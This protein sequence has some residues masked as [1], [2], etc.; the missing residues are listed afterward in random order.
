MTFAIQGV[1]TAAHLNLISRLLKELDLPEHVDQRVP[2]D[3][4]CQTKPSDIVQVLVLD[5]LSGRQA[6]VHLASWAEGLDLDVLIREGLRAKQLHDDTL[7]RHLDRLAAAGIHELV[8]SFLCRLYQTEGLSARLLH[9][10]TTSHSV[11]GRYETASEEDLA[12]TYGYSRDRPGKKQFQYGLIANEDGIPLL[13]DVHDGNLSDKTWNQ[14]VPNGLSEAVQ[15]VQLERSFLYVADSASMTGDT[16]R[17]FRQVGAHVLTRAP[18]HLKVTKQALKQGD[19][20]GAIWSEPVTYA[21]YGGAS[22]RFRETR[23]RFQDIP[24]RLLLVESSALDERKTKTLQAKWKNEAEALKDL[25]R[26]ASAKVYACEPDA[27]AAGAALVKRMKPAFHALEWAVTAIERPIRRRGRPKQGV[28][29]DRETI[30][31]LHVTVTPDDAAWEAARRRASRFVLATTLP[32]VWEGDAV[33]AETLLGWYKGQ[34]Q[35]EMNFS[36]LKDPQVTDEIY[37]KTP[38]R[39]QVLAYLFLLALAVYRVLQRR[40]RQE[41][42]PERPMKGVGGRTLTRPTARAVF[43]LFRHVQVIVI[44]APDGS[45]YRQLAKP[46]TKEQRRVL[47]GLGWQEDVYLGVTETGA[48]R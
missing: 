2:V 13:G 38:A 5:I 40:L 8:A 45:V 10:D 27:Q 39:V 26:T 3:P 37:V 47:A 19:A 46:L 24:L 22:Y 18:S 16:L 44:R 9:G 1:H 15:A 7:A 11:Y 32:E 41:I 20:P 12:I 29:P 35:V 21:E 48:P 6:L 33:S 36:F 30:Y 23:D 25:V 31:A 4:R 42:T 43:P 14:R 17:G 34:I 28:P